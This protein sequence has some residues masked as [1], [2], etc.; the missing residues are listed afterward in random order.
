MKT[1]LL[2]LGLMTSLPLL[3]QQPPDDPIGH[4][5][6]PPEVV[7]ANS[8]QLAL[9]EKQVAAIKAEIQKAQA[10]FVDVQ[11]D[12]QEETNRMSQ[13]LQQS[14]IDEAK[15]LERADRVMTLEREMKR[16]QLGLLIRLKNTLTAEQIA[17]LEGLRKGK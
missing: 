12:L 1:A 16:A 15:V 7:M 2:L 10:K 17:K 4:N 13:L 11:W 5:L 9:S 6:F 8:H 14:P 3:A